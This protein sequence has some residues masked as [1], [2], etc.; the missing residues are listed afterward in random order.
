MWKRKIFVEAEAGSSE[1]VPPPLWPFLSNVKK[2]RVVPFFVKY[3]TKSK[4]WIDHHLKGTLLKACGLVRSWAVPTPINS[5][6]NHVGNQFVFKIISIQ[7]FSII[8]S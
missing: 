6:M 7:R 8:E 1:R 2:L 3:T 4:R 5:K